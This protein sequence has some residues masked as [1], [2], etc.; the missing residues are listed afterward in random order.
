MITGPP[1]SKDIER[2]W[3]SIS[4]A[5]TEKM[6]VICKLIFPGFSI[7]APPWLNCWF[8]GKEALCTISNHSMWFRVFTRSSAF[9]A[10][11]Y[12][13]TVLKMLALACQFSSFIPTLKADCSLSSFSLP[14]QA[15]ICIVAVEES[16]NAFWLHKAFY[17]GLTAPVALCS[18]LFWIYHISYYLISKYYSLL[19]MNIFFFS[20]RMWNSQDKDHILLILVY[21]VSIILLG[22]QEQLSK[23][24]SCWRN[25]WI[26]K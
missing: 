19:F 17:L 1:G 11:L 8:P 22:T 25:T 16:L 14:M 7:L 15:L 4:F 20:P 12:S 5:C 10:L 9:K 3:I 2:V 26:N 6:V 18:I 21:P 24:M 13:M 23:Y